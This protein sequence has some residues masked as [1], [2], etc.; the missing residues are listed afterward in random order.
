MLNRFLIVFLVGAVSTAALSNSAF[1]LPE[2]KKAFGRKV[3]Q[4]KQEHT[5]QG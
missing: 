5:V 2:F 3:R 1:A 4:E